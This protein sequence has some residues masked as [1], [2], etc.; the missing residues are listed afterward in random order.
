MTPPRTHV[1]LR[2]VL[3]LAVLAVT[4]TACGGETT[5]DAGDA[6]LSTQTEDTDADVSGDTG[7]DAA[8][9]VSISDFSFATQPVAAGSQVNVTNADDTAHTVTADDGA[10]DVRV[11][12][13]SSATLTAP[14]E[15][16]E[17]DFHCDI[18]PTM[19]ATLTVQ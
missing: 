7:A 17:Y 5:T 4:L 13:A 14:E 19:K 11:G 2:S 3:L 18:H 9:G 6:G 1:R 15:P 8:A 16:G 10:F 12:A